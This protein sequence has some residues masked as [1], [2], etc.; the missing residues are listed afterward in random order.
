MAV[1]IYASSRQTGVRTVGASDGSL[2]ETGRKTRAARPARRA[3]RVLGRRGNRGSLQARAPA[4]SRWHGVVWVA[5]SLVLGVDVALKLIHSDLGRHTS[6]RAGARGACGGRP[7]PSDGARVRLRLDEPRRSVPGD[8]ARAGREL[9][10]DACVRE[11][12]CAGDSK[13]FSCL[14][15]LADGL[16]SAHDRASST[17]TV[18]PDNILIARDGSGAMQTQIAR[19]SVLP[20]LTKRWPTKTAVGLRRRRSGQSG[21]SLPSKLR[22]AGHRSSLDVWALC[23]VFVRIDHG[24]MPSIDQTTTR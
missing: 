16:R 22:V 17:A 23:V 15:P 4:R 6:G 13:R 11:L 8:G 9:G 18:K 14:L 10:L 24:K 20:K 2:S 7:A 3:N 5:H 12:R 1:R 19:S 21:Y